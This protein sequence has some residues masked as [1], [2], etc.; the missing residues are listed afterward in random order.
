MFFLLTFA[1]LAFPFEIIGEIQSSGLEMQQRVA[2]DQETIECHQNLVSNSN[3]IAID[4]E[5]TD[6]VF[7]TKEIEHLRQ[8]PL[9]MRQD[10]TFIIQSVR[11]AYKNNPSILRSR[12]IRGTREWMG[13][14]ENG[15]DRYFNKHPAKAPLTPEKV[16]RIKGLF[17]ERVS[18]CNLDL[19]AYR[20]RSKDSN[21]EMLIRRA[22]L[23][24]RKRPDLKRA[25]KMA[26]P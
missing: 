23:N 18:K 24:V 26:E 14:V 16:N 6:D 17:I 12:T 22:I 10:S 9:L 15:N 20:D 5:V 4:D 11:Y 19:L 3:I 2:N 21:I 1:F 7:T 13:I 25:R 8:I